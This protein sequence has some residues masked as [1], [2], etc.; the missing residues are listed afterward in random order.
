MS[1]ATRTKLIGGL[2]LVVASYGI[3]K[4]LQLT[5]EPV[6]KKNL[7]GVPKIGQF[8]IDRYDGKRKK[9]MGKSGELFF[10]GKEREPVREHEFEVVKK[11]K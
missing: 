3:Y 10:I 1:E 8:V 5:G 9:I 6:K 11:N 2:V 7:S 4:I